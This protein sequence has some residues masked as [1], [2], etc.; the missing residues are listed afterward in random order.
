M[1]TSPLC[2]ADHSD[3]TPHY[4]LRNSHT[5]SQPPLMQLETISSCPITYQL[6]LMVRKC[7]LRKDIKNKPA[8]TSPNFVLPSFKYTGKGTGTLSTGVT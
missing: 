3:T 7:S 1:G 4:L 5:E 2:W 8:P 6:D